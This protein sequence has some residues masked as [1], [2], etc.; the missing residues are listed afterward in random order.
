[1]ARGT[2]ERKTYLNVMKGKLVSKVTPETP[3]AISR[4]NKNGDTVHEVHDDWIS[5]KIKGIEIRTHEEYGKKISLKVIDGEDTDYVEMMMNGGYGKSFL[6]RMMNID[7]NEEVKMVPYE[8]INEDGRTVSGITFYQNDEKVDS[9]HT[10]E[11][12]NGL[13]DLE[14]VEYQ[15]KLRWDDT[16]RMRFFEKVLNEKIMPRIEEAAA[17]FIPN[18]EPL[19]SEGTAQGLGDVDPPEEKPKKKP[20]KKVEEPEE[21]DDLPF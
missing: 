4:E 8:F 17:S 11:E 10:K 19:I 9:F 14:Q 6:F 16:K 18:Q 3:G 12:K 15:G 20:K 5:G 13:P 1:M 2:K 7:F 21:E